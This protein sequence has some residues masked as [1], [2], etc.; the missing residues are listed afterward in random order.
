MFVYISAK[1]EDHEEEIEGKIEEIK[2][3]TPS[4]PMYLITEEGIKIT[5]TYEECNR[6]VHTF[7]SGIDSLKPIVYDYGKRR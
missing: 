6:I 4:G 2:F 3:C 5:L 7:T 1:N